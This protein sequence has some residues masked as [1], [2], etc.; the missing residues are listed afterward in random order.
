LPRCDHHVLHDAIAGRL[1]SVAHLACVHTTLR[2]TGAHAGGVRR[3]SAAGCVGSR[4]R[5]STTCNTA[6]QPSCQQSPL[7]A[8]AAVPHPP[9]QHNRMRADTRA[10]ARTRAHTFMAS[11][12]ARSSPVRTSLPRSTSTCALVDGR[13]WRWAAGSG[14]A[15]AHACAC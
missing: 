3:T 13:A 8:A 7:H 10:R 12:I 11:M 6:T 4:A 2:Q 15:G 1:D 14:H 5:R 9:R